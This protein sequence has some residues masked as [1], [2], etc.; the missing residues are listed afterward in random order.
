MTTQELTRTGSARLDEFLACLVRCAE[1]LP[2]RVADCEEIARGALRDAQRP[3]SM[4]P[5]TGLD[6]VPSQIGWYW[7][8]H[9]D[10]MRKHL[11]DEALC[12]SCIPPF[13]SSAYRAANLR[14]FQPHHVEVFGGF[15]CADC[16][17]GGETL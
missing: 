3:P 8:P 11:E 16:G 6:R 14:P 10:S 4:P 5:E 9:R 2:D 15:V 17:P 13:G 1:L 12:K 7:R